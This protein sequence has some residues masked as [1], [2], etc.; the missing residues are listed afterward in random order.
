MF[1]LHGIKI[2][3][4]LSGGT[5]QLFMVLHEWYDVGDSYY[6]KNVVC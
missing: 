5:T 6:F 2:V 3:N 4:P 1:Q